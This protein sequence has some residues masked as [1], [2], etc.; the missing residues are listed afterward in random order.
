MKIINFKYFKKSENW[1]LILYMQFD[2]ANAITSIKYNIHTI[3]L[4]L[5][6]IYENKDSKKSLVCK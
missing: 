2:K 3:T 5:N 1:F 4:M 6:T